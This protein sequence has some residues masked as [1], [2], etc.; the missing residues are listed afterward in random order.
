MSQMHTDKMRAS[1]LLV[2]SENRRSLIRFHNSI[3]DLRASAR[4][5]TSANRF[6]VPA[7]AAG[8][9]T[10]YISGQ[11]PVSFLAMTDGP[12]CS[13][14]LRRVNACISSRLLYSTFS[15]RCGGAAEFDIGQIKATQGLSLFLRTSSTFVLFV[16]FVA[17]LVHPGL[18]LGL[19][20]DRDS[21]G[22]NRLCGCGVSRSGPREVLDQRVR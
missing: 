6:L 4:S 13:A 1:C 10:R 5:A 18:R 2:R 21:K 19:S 11:N 9:L 20:W 14:R 7:R 22:P 15:T 8:S 12:K 3:L 17:P 16:N